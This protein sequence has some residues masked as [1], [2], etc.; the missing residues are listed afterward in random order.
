MQQKQLILLKTTHHPEVGHLYEHMYITQLRQYFAE[1]HLYAHLDY[2]VEGWTY[3]K[4]V[5]YLTVSLYTPAAV[6]CAADITAFT[7]DITDQEA[8]SRHVLQLTLENGHHTDIPDAPAL[9]KELQQL[10]ESAW[11]NI[12]LLGII[13]LQQVRPESKVLVESTKIYKHA[14]LVLRISIEDD[15]LLASHPELL[16]L[17]HQLSWLLM[18]NYIASICSRTSAYS[19]LDEFTDNGSSATL[20]NTFYSD[21]LS[22]DLDICVAAAQKS[23]DQILKQDVM[24]RF[25]DQLQTN[26]YEKGD[27][28]RPDDTLIYQETGFFIG[29]EG[30]VQLATLE[31]SLLLLKNMS[32]SID[33]KHQTTFMTLPSSYHS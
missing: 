1:N 23:T 3:G 4:G 13:N 2:H 17:F 31:N 9:N 25:L 12:D 16:V 18:H 19:A 27:F 6:S 15:E 11:R 5:I 22:T 33:Y 8:L 7:I 28:S 10:N 20:E 21:E 24:K 14:D 32:V 30:W 26:S 29:R